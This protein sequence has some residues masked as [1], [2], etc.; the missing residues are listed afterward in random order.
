MD[1]DWMPSRP[2]RPAEGC[3]LGT[4]L[5]LVLWVLIGLF[6]WGLL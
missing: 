5:G 2:L 1:D 3:I 6:V 4:L